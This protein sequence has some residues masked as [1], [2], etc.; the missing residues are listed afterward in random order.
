MTPVQH[1]TE[2]L[3]DGP[4]ASHVASRL[5]DFFKDTAP[6][7]RRLWDVS[8]VLALEEA[9]EGGDWV[10]QRVLSSGA[11]SWYLR[12]LER[13]L[14]PDHGLGDSRL[15][16]ELVT[17][18]RSG[19]G[20]H[21]RERRR[22]IQMLPMIHSGYL[23]RWG[24]HLDT[25]KAPA[26][27]RL[28]RA[29]ATHLLDR[30]HSSPELHARVNRLLR[31]EDA[32]LADLLA[33][34]QGLAEQ[35]DRDFEVLVPFVSV[36]DV[37]KLAEHLPQWRSPTDTSA[38]WRALSSDPVPRHNGAFAY[39][40]RC[41]DVAAAVRIAAAK[42]DRIQARR[43]YARTGG[44]RTLEPLGQAWI[45]GYAPFHLE[46]PGR[47]AIVLALE[48]EATMYLADADER[49]D[50]AL[51]LA[52][53][54]NGGPITSAVTGAWAAIESLLNHPGDPADHK[55]GKVVAASRLAA[56]I[57]CSWPRAELTALSHQHNSDDPDLLA[58]RLAACPDNRARSVVVADALTE[59]HTLTLRNS[60]DRAAQRRMS[61]LLGDPRRE[62][63]DVQNTLITTFRRLYRQRNIV[64]HSGSTAAAALHGTIRTAA[65]LL[66]AGL[67]R[68]VHAQL[69]DRVAPLDLAA[70]AENS[71]TLV[72]DPLGPA[73][74]DLLE[75]VH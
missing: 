53:P 15:R 2:R 56:I 40:V 19:L 55:E 13:Q 35:P 6:W 44:R 73:I 7:P 16:G 25:P 46:R 62:L 37:N 61:K 66:G 60:G 33:E 69:T 45:A 51:E 18:L 72:G 67:D 20:A 57:A 29:I 39:Q 50:E 31:N 26:P 27:E 34:T 4:Y 47:G 1:S 9:I 3:S 58:D 8:S 64:V 14:G 41:K 70:R 22:L 54:V 74:T 43:S 10:D 24:E 48:R 23:H 75:A 36:P 11:L 71:L 59:G 17:L 12:D 49:L 21:S 38:W 5:L 65:P 30:G 28:A 32:T 42:I 68:L 52:A 63:T